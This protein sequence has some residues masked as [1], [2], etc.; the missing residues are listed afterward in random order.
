MLRVHNAPKFSTWWHLWEI[1]H[2]GTPDICTIN[3]FQA[4]CSEH[5][6]IFHML[7]PCSRYFLFHLL[8]SRLPGHVFNVCSYMQCCVWEIWVRACVRAFIRVCV[9]NIV[10][11]RCHLTSEMLESLRDRICQLF[12]ILAIAEKEISNWKRTFPAFS[13]HTKFPR[14][15][16][17]LF[18]V[19]TPKHNSFEKQESWI[20][21]PI[22]K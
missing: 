16:R 17:K 21:K 4:L 2:H 7:H 10:E 20:S 11:S 18:I 9:W 14:T 3:E 19:Y 12:K 22:F 1:R 5:R 13:V 6:S 8:A 15:H